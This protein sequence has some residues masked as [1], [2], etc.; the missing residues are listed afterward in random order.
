VDA[1]R[2]ANA[3]RDPD[4]WLTP[5]RDAEGTYYSPLDA[6][7]D[8]N[9][10]RLGF[11]WEYQLGTK[12][13]LQGTPVVVDGVLYASGNWGRVYA[14]DAATGREIWTYDPG[15]DGQ[16]G[17]YACCDIVNRGLAV[18]QGRIY[19]ASV[20]GYLHAI[21]AKTGK[22]IWRT[23]TLPDRGAQAFHYFVTGAPV[24]AGDAIVIGNGGSDFK[25]RLRFEVG[26]IQVAFLHR[27][28][29]SCARQAG[30]TPSRRGGEDLA[31]RLRL[32]ERRRRHGMGRSCL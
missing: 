21:D 31:C 18:W 17:R 1:E 16:Y 11:A 15:V 4:N 19:V 13:G 5:G 25:V 14:V 32:G 3:G 8:H 7:D 9:A 12:R 6:I 24:L 23:D 27:A 29:Q 28:A 22:R 30:S 20:D 2:L 26:G 10:A